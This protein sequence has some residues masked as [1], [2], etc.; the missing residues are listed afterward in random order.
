M[1]FE[2][3]IQYGHYDSN[4]VLLLSSLCKKK[5]NKKPAQ[6]PCNPDCGCIKLTKENCKTECRSSVLCFNN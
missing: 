5:K 6:V 2:L 1:T 3:S 4:V